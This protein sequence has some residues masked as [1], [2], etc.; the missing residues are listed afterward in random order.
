MKAASWVMSDP[1]RFVAA[2]KALAAGR[3]VAG[4]DRKIKHLP[5]PGSAWTQ[6][7]DMPAPPKQTFRQWWQETHHE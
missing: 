2:E 7:K 5:Y 1:K 4:R 6:S 3:L